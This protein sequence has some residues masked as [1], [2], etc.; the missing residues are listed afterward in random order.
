MY[1][2]FAMLLQPS[3]HIMA[4]KITALDIIIVII[5]I[6]IIIIVIIII[7]I[8][9]IIIIIIYITD[10]IYKLT[11]DGSIAKILNSQ[12][13]STLQYFSFSNKPIGVMIVD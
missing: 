7:V 5:I 4:L 9:I 12:N 6:V 11:I 1:I 3:F 10:I 8:I 13:N 2:I